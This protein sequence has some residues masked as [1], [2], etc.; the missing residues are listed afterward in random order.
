MLTPS[1][2][3]CNCAG[4]RP[5]LERLKSPLCFARFDCQ[6]CKW[7][8]ADTQ[9]RPSSIQPLTFPRKVRLFSLP[10][11]NFRH[12]GGGGG[13]VAYLA[14]ECAARWEERQDVLVRQ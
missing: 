12:Q 13:E 2:A 6:A 9:I 11:L 7:Q 4:V 1:S 14:E 8:E 3:S 5:F 10:R